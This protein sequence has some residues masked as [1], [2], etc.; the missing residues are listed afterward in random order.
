MLSHNAL[1]QRKRINSA[2]RPTF[3]ELFI[4]D[5]RWSRNPW[6]IYFGI[7]VTQYMGDIGGANTASNWLGFKDISFRALRPGFI[8]GANYKFSDRLT[9]NGLGAFGV[10]SQTD[11]RS[12]NEKRGHAFNCFGMEFSA[13]AQYYFVPIKNIG[14]FSSLNRQGKR[15]KTIDIG[16]YIY[17]GTGVNVFTV[18]PN[19][20]LKND[21]RYKN[22]H[23]TFAIP[24]GIGVRYEPSQIWALEASLGR[25]FT[26]TD[27]FDGFTTIYSKHRDV[28]YLLNFSVHYRI[29]NWNTFRTGKRRKL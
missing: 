26:F 6:E 10:W 19:E 28:Y 9:F 4:A 25:R 21:S 20:S 24:V 8:G 27:G 3:Y 2:G 22:S 18:R 1:A 17:L 5:E 16:G 12:R 7:P 13:S 15:K 14:R 23:F 29:S 11:K